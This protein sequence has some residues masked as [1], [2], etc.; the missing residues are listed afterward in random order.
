MCSQIVSE[1]EKSGRGKEVHSDRH[2]GAGLTPLEGLVLGLSPPS[3]GLNV[4]PQDQTSS[5][6]HRTWTVDLFGTDLEIFLDEVNLSLI[7]VQ[8]PIPKKG[9]EQLTG[10]FLKAGTLPPPSGQGLTKIGPPAS[11]W[12]CTQ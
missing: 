12:L 11:Q 7:R 1:Q 10:N 9:S 5:H 8:T 3:P 6:S 2:Q 4:L